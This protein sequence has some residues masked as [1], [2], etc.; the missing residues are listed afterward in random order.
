MHFNLENK[1][2]SFKLKNKEKK[3][4]ECRAFALLAHTLSSNQVILCVLVFGG[5][6]ALTDLYQ[7]KHTFKCHYYF[8]NCFK[9]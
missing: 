8:L 7:D 6:L 5:A 9:L 1:E 3:E 4:K 2:Y